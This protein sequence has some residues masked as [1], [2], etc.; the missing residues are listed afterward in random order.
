MN[1]Q[2]PPIVFSFDNVAPDRGTMAPGSVAQV[3]HLVYFLDVDGFY[4]TDGSSTRP[5]GSNKVNRTFLEDLNNEHLFS[6]D[7]IVDLENTLIFWSYC[8]NTPTP[9]N[10][11]LGDVC[12]KL[13]VYNWSIDRFA[14]PINIPTETLV[15]GLTPA[16]HLESPEFTNQLTDAPPYNN[17]LVDAQYFRGGKRPTLGAFSKLHRHSSFTG[18]VLEALIKSGEHEFNPGGYA[19]VQGMRPVVDGADPDITVMLES[20]DHTYGDFTKTSGE[21][22]P[23]AVTQLAPFRQNSRYHRYTMKVSGDYDKIIGIDPKIRT[24]AIK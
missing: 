3:G 1:Y 12:D 21:V 7:A 2:G 15:Y 17:M 8:S 18:E 6:V 24:G 16:L 5:I 22:A 14:G 19:H 11:G 20:R 13:M 9:E 10:T 4:V 23:N